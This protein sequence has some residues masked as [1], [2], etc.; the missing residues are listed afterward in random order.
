MDYPY[1]VTRSF[2]TLNRRDF[3]T[4]LA[5]TLILSIPSYAWSQEGGEIDTATPNSVLI[6]SETYYYDRNEVYINGEFSGGSEDIGPQL[7][8]S[9]RA[10]DNFSTID[11]IQR[12]AVGQAQVD[13]APSGSDPRS[14][15]SATFSRQIQSEA[16]SPLERAADGLSRSSR[17]YHLYDRPIDLP[18]GQSVEANLRRLIPD[19]SSVPA[20]A[21]RDAQILLRRGGDWDYKRNGH[22]EWEDAGNFNFG[23]IAAGLGIPED[24]VLRFAGWYQQYYGA[25]NE[26]FGHWYDASGSYGDDPH[27][28]EM[29]KRGYRHHE[30]ADWIYRNEPPQYRLFPGN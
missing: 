10:P 14:Y 1:K 5:D 12:M 24:A 21:M 28:Q 25:K 15:S 3:V 29:I 7:G 6:D 30:V 4:F 13:A 22:P 2:L 20:S 23:Y 17:Q 16:G 27:D 18:P 8:I 9:S 11:V 19:P 26:K